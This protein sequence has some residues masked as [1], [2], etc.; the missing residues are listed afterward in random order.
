M[1]CQKHLFSLPDGIH[2]I[3]CATMGPNLKSV[4][5]AGIDGILRKS[6]PYQLTQDRFFVELPKV[7]ELFSRLIHNPDPERIAIIPSVS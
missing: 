1:N 6:T 5:Q 7:K 4:E 3:N 2:Y